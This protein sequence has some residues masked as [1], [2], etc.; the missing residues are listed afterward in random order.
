MALVETARQDAVCTITLNDPERLNPLS[1]GLGLALRAAIAAA[2]RDTSVRCIL[3]TGNGR[4]FCAGGDLDVLDSLAP[5]EVSRFMVESQAIVRE[6]SELAVPVVIA[7]NGAAAGAGFSLA[8]AGDILI[9]AQSATFWPA[10]AKVGAVPDLGVIH[11]LHRSIGPHRTSDLLLRGKPIDA[12][13]AH[14]LGLVSE[15]VPDETLPSRTM[16]VAQQLAA[17]PTVALGLTKK[18]I[19]VAAEGALAGFLANE[20]AAQGIAFSTA[21][22]REGVAAF[23]VRRKPQFKGK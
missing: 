17:G 10:F 1:E 12:A 20:A 8:V 18:L 5:A 2:G 3:L 16:T 21:D 15:V 4:G 11:T 7:V 9:A 22:F 14:G 23:R 13:T 6:I 19:R